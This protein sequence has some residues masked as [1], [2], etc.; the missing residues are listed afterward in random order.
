MIDLRQSESRA[1][2]QHLGSR[3]GVDPQ[4]P[5]L[6]FDFL[7]ATGEAELSQQEA[8]PMLVFVAAEIVVV[9]G[10]GVVVRLSVGEGHLG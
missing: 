8:V 1:L 4:R 5:V 3:T 7:G 6:R 2:R 10:S 9:S